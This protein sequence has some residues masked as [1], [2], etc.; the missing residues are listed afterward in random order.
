MVCRAAAARLCTPG[1]SMRRSFL[2][3]TVAATL[4][5]ALPATAQE[6]L[7]IAG[8]DAAFGDALAK[9]V[10]AYQAANPGV[11]IERL[12]LPGGALYERIALNARERTRALDVVLLDDIWAPEFM[13]NAWLADIDGLGGVTGDFIRSGDAVARRPVAQGASQGP[14]FAVPFVGNVAMFAYRTDLFAKHGLAQPT[15][16]SAV[17]AAARTLAEK[18]PGV[19]PIAFR[20]MRGNPIV[21]GFL[22]ILGA[23]GGEVVDAQGR[24]ALDNE[25]ALAALQYFLSLRPFTPRGIE[26]W[27]ANEVRGAMEQGR[28]AMAIEYWPGWA[29]TLDDTSRSRVAGQVALVPAPGEVRG[30]APMLGA[31]MLG[32]AAD[33]PN[34]ARALDFIRFA[35]STAQ[36]KRMALET[37]NP[38]ALAPLY[39]DADLVRAYRW[40]P[41]QADAL[42][43]AVARP[44]ITQWNRVEA[45]L[46]EQLQLALIGQAQPRE[47]LAEAN[48]QIA[49]ALAR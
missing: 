2:A 48:R 30:P 33:S 47:A 14:R 32:I 8:R 31:W 12:A 44:R 3:L 19:T 5:A 20:G 40:Y 49:R 10:E 6:R 16:W 27:N 18:E 45:I 34:A 38:P 41:A 15:T 13:A 29:G 39:A 35:T 17:L 28:I 7:V 37:G 21:T 26:T 25:A 36:Q 24:A 46:G 4:A 11:R 1:V 9:M 43:V 23:F 22:P 42:A